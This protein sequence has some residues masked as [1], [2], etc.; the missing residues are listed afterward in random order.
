M[1]LE[2]TTAQIGPVAIV[3]MGFVAVALGVLLMWLAATIVNI[4]ANS[5]GRA[6]L[7]AMALSII[8]AATGA[9]LGRL[10]QVGIAIAAGVAIVLSIVA[11][12]LIY[13]T[14]FLKALGVLVLNIMMQLII[15]SVYVRAMMG[16]GEPG[17]AS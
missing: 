3:V 9:I 6:F 16:T 15:S 17:G 2:E 4:K 11:I 10:S 5:L 13:R 14:G 12:K 8:T 7:A 1:A